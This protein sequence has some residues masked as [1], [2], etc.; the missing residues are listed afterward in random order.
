[1]KDLRDA[2]KLAK[3]MISIGKLAGRET[4][5]VLTNMDEPLGYSIG[6]S[7]EVKEAIE[8]LSGK[9]N[10]DVREV[11]LELGA[12]MLVLAE[13]TDDIENAKQL[14]DENLKN[15]KAYNKFM[16]LVK[17]QGGDITYL[18]D[19]DNF[20]EAKYIEPI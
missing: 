6:N 5:C 16:Q 17:M 20:E 11:V 18:S 10:K 2:E 9:I 12:Y 1:M 3:E 8:A 4:V 13:I 15:G 14:L 7:L 19:I